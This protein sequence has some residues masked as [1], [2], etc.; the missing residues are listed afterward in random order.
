MRVSLAIFTLCAALCAMPALALAQAQDDLETQ[1]TTQDDRDDPEGAPQSPL[2]GVPA[3]QLSV[4]DPD[5]PFRLRLNCP[6]TEEGLRDLARLNPER[7][8][9]CRN[10]GAGG[11]Q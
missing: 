10:L 8:E 7:A 11:R 3:S 1:I 4:G 9:L 6:S 5:D 2:F